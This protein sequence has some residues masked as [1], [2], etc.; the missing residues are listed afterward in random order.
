ML[1]S[2]LACETRRRGKPESDRQG[3]IRDAAT[4][5]RDLNSKHLA[6]G[7]GATGTVRFGPDG[8]T[9]CDLNRASEE[10]E[11]VFQQIL[12]AADLHR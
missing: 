2:K 3:T 11:Q 5:V 4:K 10:A 7:K 9:I 8:S 1:A 12:Q 6:E